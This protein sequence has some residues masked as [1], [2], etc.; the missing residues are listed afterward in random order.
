MQIQA[1]AVSSRISTSKES[2]IQLQSFDELRATE[3]VGCGISTNKEL[4]K[5]Q[6]GF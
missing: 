3:A 1:K 5:E 2:V 4:V 6:S